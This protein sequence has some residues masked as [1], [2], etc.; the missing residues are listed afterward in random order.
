LSDPTPRVLIADKLEPAGIELLQNAGIEVD[1][2]PGL[3]GADLKAA[4][5]AADAVIARSQPRITAELLADPGRLR[6]IARA[7]VGV[8]TIDVPAATRKG[9]GVMNTSG[10]NTVSAAEHTIALLLALGRKVTNYHAATKAGKYDLVAGLPIER[11]EGK[12]LG[13]VGVGQIGSLVAAKAAALGLRVIATN[14]SRHTPDN[15]TWR[16]LDELLAESD[17]VSL[18]APLSPETRQLI[19]R[20]TLARMKPSAY[21]INTSRGGLV[22]HEALAE[23]LGAGRLAGAALDVQ[24]PE[25]PKLAQPPWN[26]PRVIVTPHVAFYSTEATLDL[27]T[28]V[29]RQVVAYLRGDRPE[30][31]VNPQV[32]DRA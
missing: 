26:D 31:V 14:R 27:R 32:L 22:D 15:V 29:A 9:I 16:P 4:L 13:L 6:A 20:K 18:H 19:N 23:A 7:G 12:T 10:G 24:D 25:P 30:N 21:L 28:R 17:F 11:L 8:D 2:R 5:R 1:N 3:Q